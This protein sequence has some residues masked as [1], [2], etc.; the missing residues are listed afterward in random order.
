MESSRHLWLT[1]LW[2]EETLLMGLWLALT[3]YIAS[4]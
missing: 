2:P 3:M 1:A 4:Y